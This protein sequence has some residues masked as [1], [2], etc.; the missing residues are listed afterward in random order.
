M[1]KD[2]FKNFILKYKPKFDNNRKLWENYITTESIYRNEILD[3]II[4]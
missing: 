1:N 2:E 4:K 3:F